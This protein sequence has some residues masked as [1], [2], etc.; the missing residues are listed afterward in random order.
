MSDLLEKGAL[1]NAKNAEGY[2]PLH[3]AAVLG[4]PKMVQLLVLNGADTTVFEYLAWTPLYL[5][6]DQGHRAATLAFLAAGADVNLRC[7]DDEAPAIHAAA[8][9]GHVDILRDVIEYGAD[10]DAQDKDQETALRWAAFNKSRA[11]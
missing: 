8:H 7:G 1:I 2:T 10:M 6:G 9:H 4:T 11:R 5:A 3:I